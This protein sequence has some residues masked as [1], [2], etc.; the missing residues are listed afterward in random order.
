MIVL[1]LNVDNWY[2]H[3]DIVVTTFHQLNQGL[4]LVLEVFWDFL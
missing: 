1:D 2:S 4:Q 3:F